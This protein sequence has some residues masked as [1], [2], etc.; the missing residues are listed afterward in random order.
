MIICIVNQHTAEVFCI[1]YPI[2]A[3]V[4]RAIQPYMLIYQRGI[5]RVAA[6]RAKAALPWR[7]LPHRRDSEL[8]QER[9][10]VS[11]SMARP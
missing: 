1:S 4:T 3:T 11:L 8:R 9:F 6:F 5:E 7:E 10:F 2:K